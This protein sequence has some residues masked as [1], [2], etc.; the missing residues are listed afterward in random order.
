[1]KK[2]DYLIFILVLI[3]VL[4]I[5]FNNTA[6]TYKLITVAGNKGSRVGSILLNTKTGALWGY[7]WNGSGDEYK[8]IERIE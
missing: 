2:K 5:F 6:D 1:M 7:R 3:I 4:L 8:K